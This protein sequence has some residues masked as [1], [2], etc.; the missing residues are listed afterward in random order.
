MRAITIVLLAL[1]AAAS[2]Q[3]PCDW[4]VVGIGGGQNQGQLPY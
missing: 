2:A 4:S 3:Y 1:V